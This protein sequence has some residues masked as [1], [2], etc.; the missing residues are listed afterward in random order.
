VRFIRRAQEMGLTLE[1][2]RDRLGGKELAVVYCTLCRT[3]IPYGAEAG[4]RRFTFGTSGLL[5]RSNKLLFDHE[6][7]SLWS[8][9]EGRPV[10]GRLVG[11]AL[12]L[13][14]HPVVTTTWEEWLESHPETTVLSDETGFERDYAEG[15]AYREYFATDALMFDVPRTDE[16]LK[17]KAEVLTLL[18]RPPGSG[19]GDPRHALAISAAFLK[20]NRVHH[21]SFAGYE[22]V[23]VTSPAGANR[24]YHIA[25]GRRFTLRPDGRLED[26]Q[27]G[28]WLAAEDA[29]VS[30]PDG[31]RAPRLPAQ[32]AFWF[33]WYAQFPDTELVR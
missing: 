22:L 9:I 25:A 2:I 13:P 12:E 7:S 15:A 20:R 4:G 19:P 5:Y 16:R 33:G 28:R 14:A 1:D 23:V 32:C 21:V 31:E 18:L 26:A 10:I 3:V 17:N 6:T 27:G 24:V 29:L 30:E 8:T 11:S